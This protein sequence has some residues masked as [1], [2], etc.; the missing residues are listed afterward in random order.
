MSSSGR[1]KPSAIDFFAC[2]HGI[3]F[4][5]QLLLPGSRSSEAVGIAHWLPHSLQAA[6]KQTKRWTP[7]QIKYSAHMRRG[8]IKKVSWYI[9]VSVISIDF[10][11]H[12]SSGSRRGWLPGLSGSPL[13]GSGQ[14]SY[15][16]DDTA[17]KSPSTD[18]EPRCLLMVDPTVGGSPDPVPV[19]PPVRVHQNQRFH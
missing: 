13:L 5:T 6:D 16:S 17:G 11:P 12:C 9:A 7:T 10:I 14:T 8:V 15:C 19:I 3:S 1:G 4:E 2:F 18:T